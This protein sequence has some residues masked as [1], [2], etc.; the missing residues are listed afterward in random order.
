MGS[1]G[2]F[3]N[4]AL[5]ADWTGPRGLGIRPPS[6]ASCKIH[7]GTG[8]RKSRFC[9]WLLRV[10]SP[11]RAR[12]PAAGPIDQR[13]GFTPGE[14]PDDGNRQGRCWWYRA[15]SRGCLRWHGRKGNK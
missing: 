6:A 11:G 12:F 4:L 15:K 5:W 13:S 14:R 2:P 8:P 9:P 10:F 1:K 7:N 3:C